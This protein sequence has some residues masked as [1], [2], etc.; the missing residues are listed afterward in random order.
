M[1]TLA[2]ELRR[3]DNT[4]RVVVGV[5]APY[6]EVSYLTPDPAGEV[7]MRG[8]FK[9]SLHHRQDRVPLLRNHNIDVT[10]GWST[11]FTETDTGLEAT[12]KVNDGE[13]GDA[14]LD[15]MQMRYVTGMSVGYKPIKVTRGEGG[16]QQVVEARLVEVSMVG[17]PAYEG[18]GMIAVRNAQDLTVLLAPFTNRPDVNLTPIRSLW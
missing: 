18:A 12:F 9:R 8:A 11:R 7:M 4:E 10:L 5:V 17:I 1:T 2:M 14:L 6:N 13:Q 3:V 15:D 16:V